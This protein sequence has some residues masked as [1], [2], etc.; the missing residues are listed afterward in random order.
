MYVVL[1]FCCTVTIFSIGLQTKFY[2]YCSLCC[3]GLMN[4]MATKLE[5]PKATWF[6]LWEELQESAAESRPVTPVSH[7]TL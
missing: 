5:V 7:V 6:E 3:Q 2:M 4:A 1:H